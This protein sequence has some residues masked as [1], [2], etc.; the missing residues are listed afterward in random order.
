MGHILVN[1]HIQKFIFFILTIVKFIKT[2]N[3][4]FLCSIIIIIIIITTVIVLA[5]NE[6]IFFVLFKPSI[7]RLEKSKLE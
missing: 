2:L 1:F 6:F 5:L 3:F 4:M 7:I